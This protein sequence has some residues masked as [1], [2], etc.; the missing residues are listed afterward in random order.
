MGGGVPLTLFERDFKQLK[1]GQ[2]PLDTGCVIGWDVVPDTFAQRHHF[3]YS[4]AGRMHYSVTH[5][6]YEEVVDAPC[7][8]VNPLTWRPA[9]QS[10]EITAKGEGKGEHLG[11]LDMVWGWSWWRLGVVVRKLVMRKLDSTFKVKAEGDYVV[12][13]EVTDHVPPGVRLSPTYSVK[14]FGGTYHLQD[15]SLFYFN[16]RANAKERIAAFLQTRAIG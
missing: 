8:S 10:G 1:V 5:G 16:I 7:L 11:L 15:F 13:S 9:N 4:E 6:R 3:Y 14:M 2:G 12:V